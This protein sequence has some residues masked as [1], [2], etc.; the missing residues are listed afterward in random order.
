MKATLLLSDAAQESG[1][2]L[3]I[4]GGGWSV[5]RT[6]DQPINMA[7]ALKFE[8]DWNETNRQHSLVAELL[9]QDGQPVTPPGHPQPLRIEGKLEAGRPAGLPPGTAIDAPLAINIAGIQLP[10]GGYRWQVTVDGA[11]VADASFLV[12]PGF[13]PA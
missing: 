4:L 7:L 5:L 6:A 10:P 1:G 8:I 9:N 11:P 3:Y 2:K 12:L 13:Q